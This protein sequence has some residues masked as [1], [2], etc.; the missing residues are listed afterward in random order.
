VSVQRTLLGLLVLF[1]VMLGAGAAGTPVN[2]D[3]TVAATT[4]GI[5]LGHAVQHPPRVQVTSL[6]SLHASRLVLLVVLLAAVIASTV[7][8][9]DERC[10]SLLWTERRSQRGPPSAR[11]A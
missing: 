6:P 7:S 2:G 1:A 10:R 11:R 9:I 4:A 5:N 3:S 8:Y